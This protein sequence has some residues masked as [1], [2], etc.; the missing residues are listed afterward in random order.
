MWSSFVNWSLIGLISS[1]GI[2]SIP[3]A[4]ELWL[5][6]IASLIASQLKKDSDRWS[7]GRRGCIGG[8]QLL[9]AFER[10]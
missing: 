9:V 1:I 8:D 3:G 10:L 5:C 7:I 2:L 4:L 6:F